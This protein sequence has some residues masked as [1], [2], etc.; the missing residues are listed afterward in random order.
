M[1]LDE[2]M[3]EAYAQNPPDVQGWRLTNHDKDRDLVTYVNRT[4]DV[5]VTFS[6]DGWVA[7]NPQKQHDTI[8]SDQERRPNIKRILATLSEGTE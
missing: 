6:K 8:D 2:I 5:S 4:G 3:V 1:K 7:A